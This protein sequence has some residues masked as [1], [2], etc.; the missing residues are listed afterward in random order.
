M[1]WW[2]ELYSPLGVTELV[3]W[4][5]FATVGDTSNK[6]KSFQSPVKCLF[7]DRCYETSRGMSM[8]KSYFL[9]GSGQ[10]HHPKRSLSS[11][12]I[13][14][15][16]SKI[17]LIDIL[18]NVSPVSEMYPQFWFPTDAVGYHVP[19][20]FQAS[21]PLPVGVNILDEYASL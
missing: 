2:E 21:A 9:I 20:T 18:Q 10:T 16:P 11:H 15:F 1:R 7:P 8:V 6:S 17:F 19:T 3:S 13:F 14:G 4:H 12:L 5:A